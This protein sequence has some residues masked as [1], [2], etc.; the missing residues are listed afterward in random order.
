MSDNKH[1][2]KNLTSL[3]AMIGAGSIMMV[4]PYSFIPFA[5]I[6]CAFVAWIACYMYRWRNRGNELY[7]F[8]TT[9]LIRTIW[10]SSLILML[11]VIVFGSII[12]GNGD[13]S[14]INAMMESAQRGVI[15]DQADILRMQIEFVRANSEI[16]IGAGIFCLLPYPLFLMYRIVRGIRILTKKEG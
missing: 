10:W 15:A 6:A 4:I 3:Y 9:Y 14:A 8:H 5:G 7:Q 13:M 2:V 1:I 12:F 11:G 16:I